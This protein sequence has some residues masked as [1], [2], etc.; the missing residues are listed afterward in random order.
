MPVCPL[1]LTVGALIAIDFIFGISRSIKLYGICSITSRKMSNTIS[2]ILLY[3]LVIITVYLLEIYLIQTGL[4]LAKMAAGLIGLT[5][6]LSIDESFKDIF[7]WSF[8]GK[9]RK[10]ILRGTSETKDLIKE[11][12]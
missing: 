11:V 6:V 3:N 5:E 1:M 12:K 9:L 8:W 10:L 7:G 4:P 2:K